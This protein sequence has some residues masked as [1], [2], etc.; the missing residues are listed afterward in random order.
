MNN[1]VNL[2]LIKALFIYVQQLLQICMRALK[3]LRIFWITAMNYQG[4][5][6]FKCEFDMLFKTLLLY[7]PLVWSA[8]AP[9]VIEPALAYRDNLG[10]ARQLF[11]LGEDIAR[12]VGRR[13]L[14]IGVIGMQA[15]RRPQKIILFSE[16]KSCP[17]LF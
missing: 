9:K 12:P 2:S 6:E 3:R 11:K 13:G 1:D 14:S 16:L 15:D 8:A 7:S 17:A 5:L 4:L 10:V